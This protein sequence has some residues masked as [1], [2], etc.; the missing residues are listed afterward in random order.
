[1]DVGGDAD[2]LVA[3]ASAVGTSWKLQGARRVLVRLEQRLLSL[4]AG[5]G[6]VPGCRL[7]SLWRP[8]AR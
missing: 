4:V 3:P 5:A 6:A 1:M 7:E 2:P 8:L